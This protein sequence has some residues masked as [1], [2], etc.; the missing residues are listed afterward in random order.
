LLKAIAQFKRACILSSSL[1]DR[2]YHVKFFGGIKARGPARRS[3]TVRSGEINENTAKNPSM[4]P[5]V[6]FHSNTEA[7]K[8]MIA[9][10]RS[11]TVLSGEMNG[12]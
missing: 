9:A 8:I 2:C 11:F 5:S 3:F 6:S 10:H 4:G 7:K 12:I 1:S